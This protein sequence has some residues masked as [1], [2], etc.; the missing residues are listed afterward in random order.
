MNRIPTQSG[1]ALIVGLV[2]LLV[3]TVIGVA[4]MQ[5]TSLEEKMAGNA[6]G[7]DLA[8]Q[9]AETALREGEVWLRKTAPLDGN[10]RCTGTAANGLDASGCYASSSQTPIWQTIENQG[11]WNDSNWAVQYAGSLAQVTNPPSYIVEQLQSVCLPG[12]PCLMSKEGYSYYYRIIARGTGST[13]DAVAI[14]QSTY[15]TK[16]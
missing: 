10:L 14:V 15:M 8:F 7:R 1:G 6:R 4:G 9:A 3:M 2:M 12:D 13:A 11:A 16:K 5:A